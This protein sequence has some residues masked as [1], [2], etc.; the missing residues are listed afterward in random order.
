M[1]NCS[2]LIIFHFL[3]AITCEGN[4]PN[5]CEVVIYLKPGSIQTRLQTH[6]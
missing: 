1:K 6:L 3:K 5:L 4:M 2:V